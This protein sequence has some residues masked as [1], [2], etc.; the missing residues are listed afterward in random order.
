MSAHPL[1]TT[2]ALDLANHLWQSTLVLGIVAL[3]TLTLRQTSARIRYWLWL[4]AS[5]KFLI[6]FSLLIVLGAHLASLRPA[7]PQ[8]NATR[9][10]HRIPPRNRPTQPALSLSTDALPNPKPPKP[11]HH[12][13]P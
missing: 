10:K 4:T 8:R 1:S 13:P 7:S 3:L 9:G 11:P 6:P 12:N 5:I 2:V